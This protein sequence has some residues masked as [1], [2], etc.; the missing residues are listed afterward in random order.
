MKSTMLSTPE[1]APHV[2]KNRYYF[3]SSSL[4]SGAAGFTAG[5]VATLLLHPLD[6]MKVRYQLADN[7]K[8]G[9]NNLLRQTVRM[10][11]G[12]AFT[13]LIKTEGVRGLWT[14]LSPNL[15]GNTAAWGLYF[16]AFDNMKHQIR[17]IRHVKEGK[18]KAYEHLL[19]ASVSGIAVLSVTNPLWVVKTR[20][21]VQG[22][23]PDT[24]RSMSA[25]DVVV[26]NVEANNKFRKTASMSDT[27][28]HKYKGTLDGLYKIAK[29]EGYVM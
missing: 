15:I 17:N 6:L 2:E 13:N 12:V 3:G 14:G 24:S 4:D 5:T 23:I 25:S 16:M 20:M 7:T 27:S 8:Q 11:Y 1:S 21:C 28:L 10:N 19:A 29:Y 26:E 9:N 18:L 22:A